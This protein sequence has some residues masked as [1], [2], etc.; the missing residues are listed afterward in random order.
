MSSDGGDEHHGGAGSSGGDGAGAGVG[1]QS[2]GDNGDAG[3]ASSMAPRAVS[4]RFRS[5]RGGLSR[6][7]NR[8]SSLND[9]GLK[10]G[11][12]RLSKF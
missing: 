5:N 8:E 1:A 9:D 3:S 12:F 11:R 6:N 10:C 4:T 2:A 7:R